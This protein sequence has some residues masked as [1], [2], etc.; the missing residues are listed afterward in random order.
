[1][2]FCY[3]IKMWRMALFI[4]TIVANAKIMLDIADLMTKS[5]KS[6]ELIS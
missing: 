2:L 4:R 5:K 1:M 3:F 6:Y